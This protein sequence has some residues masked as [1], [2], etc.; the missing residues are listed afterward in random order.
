VARFDA[1][2]PIVN[3][4][5]PAQ[6]ECLNWWSWFNGDQ[7]IGPTTQRWKVN[8]FPSTFVLDHKG[9]IRYRD[10]R[11]VKLEA[12]VESLLREMDDEASRK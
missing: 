5:T 11:G 9:S 6:R 7:T 10:L 2:S 12:A 4:P 8:S 3:S 1:H